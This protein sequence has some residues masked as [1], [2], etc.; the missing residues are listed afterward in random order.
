[1]STKTKITIK[2]ED[3]IAAYEA[4]GDDCI[5][6]DFENIRKFKNYS[7][8]ID[9]DIKLANGSIVGVRDWVQSG[10]IVGS[11]IRSPDQRRYESIRLG[12]SYKDQEGMDNDNAKALKYL[13]TA[14]QNKMEELKAQKIVTDSA[15]AK[16]KAG[17]PYYLIS[18]KW[19][20]P[21]QTMA[22]D[23]KTSETVILDN[24]MFWISI[25][26]KKF[27]KDSE[28]RRESKVLDGKYYMDDDGRTPDMERPVKTFDLAPM[29]HNADD[30]QCPPNSQ[31]KIYKKLGDYDAGINTNYIDNANIQ[32]YLT[33]GSAI[34]G[35]L[36]FEVAVSGRQCKFDVSLHGYQ[37]VKVAPAAESEYQQ[38]D[39]DIAAFAS[40]FAT[41]GGAQAT[42]NSGDED[43][44]DYHDG[45]E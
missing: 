16:N 34:T 27:Y 29:F 7:Q 41:I 31:R 9:V 18:T 33:R 45:D 43:F 17:P 20:T 1:M 38:D 35:R 21:M 37:Y 23:K 32:D 14:F 13:C 25:P 4:H 2:T 22:T 15:S 40:R 8:Y 24:P 3:I 5:V 39:I 6:F 11:R 10:L 12:V 26:K 36:K 19:E 28:P 42:T 30:F 44:E